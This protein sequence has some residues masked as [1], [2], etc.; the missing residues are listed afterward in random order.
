[1]WNT[2]SFSAYGADRLEFSPRL[3][4]DAGVRIER[5]TGN[6]RGAAQDIRWFDIY[7][8]AGVRWQP[9]SSPRFMIF[10]G[11]GRYGYQLP[12]RW[13]AAGDPVSPSG[14]VFR[15]LASEGETAIDTADVGPLVARVGPGTGGDAGFST[16]DPALRRPF[17]DEFVL[18]FESA[19]G[20]NGLVRFSGIG[21]RERNHAGIVNTGVP[22]SAFSVTTVSDAGQ[23]EIQ[24]QLPGYSQSP[25]T[26]GDDR[27]VLTNPAEADGT[28]L[29]LDL[30]YQ[31]TTERLTLVAG[32]TAGQFEGYPAYRG[33][34]LI[35]NDRGLL[36]ETF[37]NPNAAP[38]ALGRQFTE[39]AYTLKISGVYRFPR[40]TRLGVIARYLDGQPFARYVIFDDL[41]QGPEPVRAFFNGGTRFTFIMTW[42][43]RL[44]KSIELGNR[45]LELVLDVYN[46]IHRQEEIEESQVD[47]PTWRA[48]TAVVPPMT[49]HAGVRFRF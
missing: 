48:V 36:G 30:S 3:L 18:G 35:E 39:R 46:F 17:M 16:L 8:R 25:D 21:R 15:W 13:L 26:F 47:G 5:V 10:S 43:A 23:G 7:P 9:T 22:A 45:R 49:F 12:M 38:H 34:T 33:F 44:Q 28:F 37:S 11:G 14:S 29:G 19:L 40:E 4:V 1:V 41:N 6:A 31:R 24:Q 32:A 2:A 42:D 20:T 27:Y